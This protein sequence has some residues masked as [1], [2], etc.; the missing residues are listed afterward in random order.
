[1]FFTNILRNY[2]NTFWFCKSEVNF[3]NLKHIK[4]RLIYIKI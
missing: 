3:V 1:M 2:V 4:A